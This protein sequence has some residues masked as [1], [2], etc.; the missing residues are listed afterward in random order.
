V[1]ART[2]KLV[3]R[4]L[5]RPATQVV[6]VVVDLGDEPGLVSERVAGIAAWVGKQILASGAQVSLTSMG[7]DGP[8]TSIV[9]T[10]GLQRRLA[11]ARTGT[12]PLPEGVPVLVVSRAGVEW[13]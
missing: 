4:E 1:T 7:P 3:T 5:E 2:G 11:E 13:T 12:P 10:I 8:A 6:H 9:N